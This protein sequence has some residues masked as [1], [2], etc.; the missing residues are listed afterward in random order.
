MKTMKKFGALVLAVVMAMALAVPASAAGHGSIAISKAVEGHTYTA[1]Q[2]FKGDFATGKLSNIEWGDDISE[3]GKTALYTL[4]GLTGDNQTAAKVAQAIDEDT[5]HTD[6]ARIVAE[7]IGENN[8]SGGKT[9]TLSSGTYTIS[10]LDDGYYMII[11]TYTPSDDEKDVTYSRY[12]VQLVDTATVENK[13]I[14]VESDKEIVVDASGTTADENTVN[15]GDTVTYKLTSKVP[16]MTGY[17]EYYMDFVDTMG[18]GLTYKTDGTFTITVGETTLTA[19]DYTLTVGEYDAT[20]G[21]S[22]TIHLKDFVSRNYTADSDIVIQYQAVVNDNAVIG[23]EG[24]PNTMHLEYSNNPQHSGDGT[25]DNPDQD[26]VTGT[27]PDSVVKSY[28]TKLKLIKVDGSDNTKK[29]EG[30]VFNVTGTEI[31]KVLITGTRFVESETGTFYLLKDNTYTDKAPTEA[32]KDQYAELEEGTLNATKKYA[33]EAY[34]EESVQETKDVAFQVI[35]NGSGEIEISGL[36][37]GTYTFTE[38]QAPAGY[39]LLTDPITVTITSTPSAPASGSTAATEF[40]WSATG[41]GVT[42]ADDGTISFTV[43]NNGGAELPETGGIGTKIF[44]TMGAVLVIG[45]GVV[46]VSRKRAAE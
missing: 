1:Y 2:I 43:E 15:I 32:T 20:N 42:V 24:N 31:N 46:L 13:A 35:T 27:T 5:T 18:K 28:V 26:V 22:I 21:T 37:E 17:K 34:G 4:Y 7:T 11:D 12:M 39:N 29:L 8:V 41:N 36:K 6:P 10:D 23:N 9:G 30:A 33:K 45:A 40:A 16:D 14:T 44:Y 19:D 3:A 25:P 38:I